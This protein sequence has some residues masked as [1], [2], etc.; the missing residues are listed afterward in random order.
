NGT[1]TLTSAAETLQ[2]TYTHSDD[3]LR[4][5]FNYQPERVEYFTV[6]ELTDQNLL[7]KNQTQTFAFTPRP[8]SQTL[9]EQGTIIPNQ[10][11]SFT[12]LWRGALGM[13][14]LIFIAFI[15]SHN[16]SAIN[17]KTVGLG[18][19]AQLILAIGILEVSIVQNTFEWL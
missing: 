18:L 11:F 17:W 8:T 19:A 9:Q 16:R 5:N 14:V 12:S 7:L 4:L 1:F 10:G 13:L 15:F 6:S 3:L 2:G